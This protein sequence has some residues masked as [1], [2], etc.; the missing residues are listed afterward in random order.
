M[1]LYPN[2]VEEAVLETVQSEFESQWGHQ[3]MRD[4]YRG[5]ILLASTQKTTVRL[6]D[7]APNK[8]VIA[9]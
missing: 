5:L 2:L 8:G 6:R 1:P 3:I 4:S 9:Q 7:P